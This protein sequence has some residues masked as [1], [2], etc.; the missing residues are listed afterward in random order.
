MAKQQ[1]Q[2]TRK[3]TL[4]EELLALADR[5]QQRYTKA[6]TLFLEAVQMNPA[7]GVAWHGEEMAKVQEPHERLMH[8]LAYMKDQTP[9][10]AL[11]DIIDE[12]DRRIEGFFGSQS[13]SLFQNAVERARTEGLVALKRDLDFL[14]RKYKV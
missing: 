11:R 5:L 8:I 14:A 12:V 2:P 4:A 1:K 6:K 7:D 9:E 3:L 13:T 10:A